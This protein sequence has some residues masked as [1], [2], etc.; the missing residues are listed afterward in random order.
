VGRLSKVL[1]FVVVL[2]IAAAG[3][4]LAANRIGNNDPNT[5]T[6]TDGN[7]NIYGLGSADTLNGLGGNDEISGNGGPDT[8]NGGEGDDTMVGGAGVDKMNAGNSIDC[9]NVGGTDFVHS[10]DGNAETVCFGTGDG[11]FVVDDIDTVKADPSP[12][13][14]CASADTVQVFPAP[15]TTAAAV[16]G[17][18]GG[19]VSGSVGE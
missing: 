1:L 14:D 4:A 2:V 8:M 7:D 12:P 18:D 13:T 6:G 15:D 19:V 9:C 10:V 3:V 11:I 17:T 5:L 16:A